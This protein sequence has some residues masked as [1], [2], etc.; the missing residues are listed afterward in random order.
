MIQSFLR[1]RRVNIGLDP[2]NVL[3]ASV[4]LSQAKYREP[5]QRATFYKQLVERM[6]HLPGVE[7]A[8]ATTGRT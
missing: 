4:N 3:T 7:A 6:R 8:S 5:D 1:L 2:K